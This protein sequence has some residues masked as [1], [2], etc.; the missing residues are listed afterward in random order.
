MEDGSNNNNREAV[1]AVSNMKEFILNVVEVVGLV[2]RGALNNNLC[3]DG[4]MNVVDPSADNC[5]VGILLL[6]LLL[7]CEEQLPGVID[8]GAVV[9]KEFNSSFILMIFFVR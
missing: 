2:L 4:I 3:L 7:L 9:A 6:L 5:L 8:N 1:A